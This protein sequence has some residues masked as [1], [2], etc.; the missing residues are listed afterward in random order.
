MNSTAAQCVFTL[1]HPIVQHHLTQLRAA[2]TPP[3]EFRTIVKRLTY[4][5]TLAATADLPLHERTVQTPLT[6][7]QGSELT[8]RIGL[9]PILRAGLG[10]VEAA[11]EML[12]ASEVWHLGMYRDES[13]AQPVTYYN[14]LP[15]G[16]PVEIALVLDP[17]LATGGS[18]VAAIETLHG[19]GAQD[20]RLLSIIAADEGVRH[21]QH[22]FPQTRIFV[23]AID[24]ELNAQKFI[25]PGL[26]DAG[27]RIFG[28]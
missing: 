9:A 15:T 8:S 26:G 20:I 5:L 11:Q 10:M 22:A 14:K 6:A 23:C 4:A 24:A 25:V 21:V 19:W 1:S 18:A 16:R 27:D 17:M 2:D 3:V 7:H 12:P 28:T 13:T